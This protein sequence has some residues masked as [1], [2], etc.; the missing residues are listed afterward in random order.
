M[1]TCLLFFISTDGRTRDS[2]RPPEKHGEPVPSELMPPKDI[3]LI[4]I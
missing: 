3:N 1:L 4:L 2:G